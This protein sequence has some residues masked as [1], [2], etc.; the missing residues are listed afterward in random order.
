MRS[1]CLRFETISVRTGRNDKQRDEEVCS[2]RNIEHK[3]QNVDKR[4]DGPSVQQQDEQ[5]VAVQQLYT[6][7]STKQHTVTHS[8]ITS[9]INAVGQ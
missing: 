9:K 5:R 6:T 1:A 4:N 2:R 8:K 7:F 3:R